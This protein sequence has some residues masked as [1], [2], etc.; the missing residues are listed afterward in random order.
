LMTDEDAVGPAGVD[1]RVGFDPRD[2][3]GTGRSVGV[4]QERQRRQGNIPGL[5]SCE[6]TRQVPSDV[7]NSLC[8][9][10]G[11]DEDISAGC[12]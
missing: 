9:C 8:L 12:N 6:A 7:I 2:L 3:P 11:F 1:G 5:P 4:R 10:A